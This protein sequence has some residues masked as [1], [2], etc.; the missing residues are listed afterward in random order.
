MCNGLSGEQMETSI[1]VGT[2]YYQRLRHMVNDKQQGRSIGTMVS[3]TRQPTEGRLR[4][5]GFRIGEMERD[6]I[7]SHG[8]SLFCRERFYDVS[9]KYSTHVCEKC[10]M[11]AAFNDV[12]MKIKS[13]KYNNHDMSV[14]TCTMCNNHTKIGRAHV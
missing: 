9:D 3:L 4:V 8:A 1:F 7:V 12:S 10:G 2:V 14:H 13:K 5:G 6:V 11:I